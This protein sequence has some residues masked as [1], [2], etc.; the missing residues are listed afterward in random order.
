VRLRWH[1]R[2]LPSSGRDIGR[3]AAFYLTAYSYYF[4]GAVAAGGVFYGEVG[5]AVRHYDH[6][7]WFS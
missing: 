7:M 1:R 6:A 4:G 3:R 2:A 5:Y